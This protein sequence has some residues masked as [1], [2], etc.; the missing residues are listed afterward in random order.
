MASDEKRDQND[1]GSIYPEQPWDPVPNPQVH[2]V[3][4]S[5]RIY[6]HARLQCSFEV[7]LPAGKSVRSS[8]D[9]AGEDIASLVQG[10][11]THRARRRYGSEGRM[12]NH[13][14]RYRFEWSCT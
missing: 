6:A 10:S 11:E 5:G 2:N 3:E 1:R 12:G 9:Q 8:H 4:S 13:G 14:M 7:P